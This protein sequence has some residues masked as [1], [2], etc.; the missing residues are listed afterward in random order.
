[1]TFST[2]DASAG[3]WARVTR[4]H[5]CPACHHEGWC[6][7]HPEGTWC[8]CM[9]TPSERPHAAGGWLHC[10]EGT[11]AACPP[12]AVPRAGIEPAPAD[13]R[14]RVFRELLAELP[15]SPE[16][17]AQLAERGLTAANIAHRGYGSLPLTRWPAVRRTLE[18][19]GAETLLRVP[20]FWADERG[21][22]HL[23]G[24]PGLLVPSRDLSGRILALVVRP[25]VTE[26]PKYLY[27]SSSS[28]GGPSPGAPPHVPLFDGDR[29]CIRITEGVLKAD[30]ATA[31]SGILTVGAAGVAAWRTVLP[32][33]EHLKPERVSVA[34]DADAAQNEHVARAERELVAALLSL[35]VRDVD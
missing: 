5:P 26:G 16:H 29:T 31:L 4:S 21:R 20:G 30:V 28:R 12:V 6:T 11:P 32:V 9:R 17:R 33:I 18:A 7:L 14:D 2:V 13:V 19:F 27:L 8:R 35:E 25:D 23:A 3:L 34:F 10:I 1:M 22:V 15:L 24:R